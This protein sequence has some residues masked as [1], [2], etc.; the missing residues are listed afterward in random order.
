MVY[1][2]VIDEVE[3][4]G[5]TIELRLKAAKALYALHAPWLGDYLSNI[6]CP[7][8][9]LNGGKDLQVH[10][11]NLSCIAQALIKGGND[12]FQINAFPTS[13]ICFR[14]QRQGCLKST[15]RLKRGLSRVRR[16]AETSRSGRGQL[17]DDG[18]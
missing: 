1:D 9:A 8:L 16:M 18:F 12:Q 5:Q 13:T 2:M 4:S 10:P 11:D 3:S 6:Q 15:R 14:E 17:N 7:V